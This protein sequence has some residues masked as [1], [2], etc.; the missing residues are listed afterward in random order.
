MKDIELL[1]YYKAYCELTVW[2]KKIILR[3]NARPA[4]RIKD[5]ATE[6][7]AERNRILLYVPV[8]SRK[9]VRKELN[10]IATSYYSKISHWSIQQKITVDMV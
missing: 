10:K 7:L 9:E 3:S 6:F 2:F 4:I 5:I 1:N 8:E